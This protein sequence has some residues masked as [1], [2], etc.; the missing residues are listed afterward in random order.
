MGRALFALMRWIRTNP[1]SERAAYMVAS[2]QKSRALSCRDVA[3]F[4]TLN[5]F[6]VRTAAL[7]SPA[8]LIM[9][10]FAPEPRM[11]TLPP[12]G[13]PDRK[14][15]PEAIHKCDQVASKAAICEQ[16]YPEQGRSSRYSH[17]D[18]RPDHK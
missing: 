10:S 13:A 11:A 14:D 15:N 1:K 17:H 2:Q 8:M 16:R 5:F 4:L 7:E 18:G 12:S 6:G 3:S 9:I